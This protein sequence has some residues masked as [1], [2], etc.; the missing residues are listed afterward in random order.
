MCTCMRSWK[1]VVLSGLESRAFAWQTVGLLF[2]GDYGEECEGL[3][4]IILRERSKNEENEL[5]CMLLCKKL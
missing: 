3:R 1:R 5:L 4:T 2:Q